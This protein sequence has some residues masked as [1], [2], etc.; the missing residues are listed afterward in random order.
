MTAIAAERKR[1]DLTIDSP[2]RSPPRAGFERHPI[3]IFKTRLYS[4]FQA[5]KRPVAR[6]HSI[7]APIRLAGTAR[8][9]KNACP[10]GGNRRG[11]GQALC[12][13]AEDRVWPSIS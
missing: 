12:S 10:S 2:L 4:D 8:A 13:N 9:K 7:T 3:P 6:P 1:V 11:P 5:K